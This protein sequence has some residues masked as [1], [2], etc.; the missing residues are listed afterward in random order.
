M[1][2]FREY[3]YITEN[4]HPSYD[5]FLNE[6]KE[7]VT[8]T[9]K[10]FTTQ[11][12]TQYGVYDEEFKTWLDNHQEYVPQALTVSRIKN[13]EV[14]EIPYN[15][16]YTKAHEQI[17]RHLDEAA[18]AIDDITDETLNRKWWKKY[19]R[20]LQS[21]FKDNAWEKAFEHFLTL[22]SNSP[23][24]LILGPIDTYHDKEKG[25]KQFFSAWLLVKNIAA[26]EQINI[27]CEHLSQIKEPIENPTVENVS[28]FISDLLFSGGEVAK[29][30]TM[31]W[32]RAGANGAI[33][34]IAF[35]K[36]PE[37]TKRMSDAMQ[38]SFGKWK[39]DKD[40]ADAILTF[41]QT[42]FLLPLVL[43]EYSHTYNKHTKA[44]VNLG[45]YYTDIEEARANTYMVHLAILLENSKHLR[46]HSARN[47]FLRVLLYLPYLYE[48]YTV[49]KQRESYYFAGLL[50]LDRALEKGIITFDQILILNQN[51]LDEKID[52]TIIELLE[53]F[54]TMQSKLADE[55]T[56]EK[57]KSRLIQLGNKLATQLHW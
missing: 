3:P 57:Q 25:I 38:K 54:N 14:V 45:K 27:L 41:H 40:I 10:L 53:Y 55:N 22:P 56:L 47:M 1:S 4:L 42:E 35:N 2:F 13:G 23:I 18:S 50:W 6:I 44:N 39:I 20:L 28:F 43:H 17:V 33:K 5:R 30:N 48:E 12:H 32:S 29:H 49:R 31:G 46:P 7:I 51:A 16:F 21:A 37:H 34:T 15:V 26:Q 9:D 24:S 8:I 52:K 11:I 19:M 36:L